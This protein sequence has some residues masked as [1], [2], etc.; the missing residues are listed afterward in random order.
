LKRIASAPVDRGVSF[1][2]VLWSRV[3]KKSTVL[4]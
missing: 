2:R 4:L 3:Q 1:P